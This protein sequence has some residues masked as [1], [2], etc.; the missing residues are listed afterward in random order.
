GRRACGEGV[1]G[2]VRVDE[3][4]RGTEACSFELAERQVERRLR[5]RLG[6]ALLIEA[7]GLRRAGP[8]VEDAEGVVGLLQ[9]AARHLCDECGEGVGESRFAAQLLAASG[10][11]PRVVGPEGVTRGSQSG[12]WRQA[13]RPE[14]ECR[15]AP[16]AEWASQRVNAPGA[17]TCGIG[18]RGPSYILRPDE[19]RLR[20]HPR[21]RRRGGAGADPG[22]E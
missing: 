17:E 3:R 22:G 2:L 14:D 9:L 18:Q 11:T 21:T 13:E 19:L 10:R 7:R 12:P 4:R 16:G 5:L 1:P 15:C 6:A 8:R 20:Q